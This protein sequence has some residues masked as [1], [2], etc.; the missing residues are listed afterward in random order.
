MALS[1]NPQELA[2]LE[3]AEDQNGIVTIVYDPDNEL[4][5]QII[6]YAKDFVEIP[7]EPVAGMEVMFQMDVKRYLIDVYNFDVV[8]PDVAMA[9]GIRRSRL[10][11]KTRRSKRHRGHTVRR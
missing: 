8:I 7:E 10:H 2:I 4:H 3:D 5:E 1:V 6:Q 11:K 9:A